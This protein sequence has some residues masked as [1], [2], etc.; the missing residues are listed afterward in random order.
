M[1]LRIA[2]VPLLVVGL[3][4]GP[5]VAGNPPVVEHVIV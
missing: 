2:M 4:L 5:A 1:L 3:C